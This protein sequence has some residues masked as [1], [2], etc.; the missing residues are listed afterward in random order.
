MKYIYLFL[1]LFPHFIYAQI[2]DTTKILPSAE[3]TAVRLSRYAVGQQQLTIDSADLKSS[4]FQNLGDLLQNLT[5]LS[6]KA[7]GVGLSTAT[8]RG[9]GSRHTALVWNGLNIQNG[10]IGLSDLSALEVGAVDKMYVKFGG[11]SALFGSGAIGGAIFLDNAIENT[12]G[13]HGNIG[14]NAG[15]FGL[16]GQNIKL[17]IGNE[18]AA[19]QFRISH[20]KA[21]NDFEFRDDAAIGKP[22][23]YIQNAAFDKLN[24]T[25]SLFFNLGKNRFLKINNWLSNIYR[26]IPPTKLEGNF[27]DRQKEQSF[28]SVAE[29]STPLSINT[30][31]G[32]FKARTGFFNEKLNYES[33]K[34]KNSENNIRTFIGEAETVFN[35]TEN[36][37]LRLG[38]NFT[39]NKTFANNLGENN[40]IRNRLALFASQ[41]F[42][43]KKT[44]FSTNIRQ[45]VVD[46]Q[47]VPFVFSLGFER[48]ISVPTTS[49]VIARHEAIKL[50]TQK[51]LRGSFSRN[52]NIPALNDLYWNILGNP[53][54]LAERGISGELG[55]DFLKK[56]DNSTS[57]LGFTVFALK[58]NNWIQWS[59][60]EG[61][62]WRPSNLK[63]VFSRGVELVFKN[64][65]TI[66]KV[67]LKTH[68]NYQLS[69][70]SE[71][72]DSLKLQLIYAPIHAGSMGISANYKHFYLNYYQNASSKRR[73]SGDFTQ[74]FTLA[75]ATIGHSFL[76]K[77][78]QLNTA[79][80]IGNIWNADYEV[81]RFYAQPRRSFEG[82]I[83]FVF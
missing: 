64:K 4:P 47:L 53:N 76:I 17:K 21:L 75:N 59:P 80:Q 2:N 15:S 54:L 8:S 43:L 52:Y 81:I 38:T 33:D 29:F 19:G 67:I 32:L 78:Y 30:T 44:K 39:Q 41:V 51:L 57:T 12:N 48:P 63:K 35:F 3:I 5:P 31:K 58:T 24:L 60:K 71:L 10:L 74:P 34:V 36:K 22:I 26:E 61:S 55:I 72:G 6:I 14:A 83:N 77:N 65:F 16:L 18:Q 49:E 46:N 11:S 56:M 25:N 7:Y 28:R 45:E 27:N 40:H 1:A 20:Q 82:Q 68:F 37:S 42:E 62:N 50:Q 70:A 23:K 9:T 69:R 66:N 13:L 73:V 79:L